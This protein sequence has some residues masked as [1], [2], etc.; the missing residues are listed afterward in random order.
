MKESIDMAERRNKAAEKWLEGTS[1]CATLW[2]VEKQ[3]SNS[4]TFSCFAGDTCRCM[5]FHEIR[6]K[7]DVLIESELSS[8]MLL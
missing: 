2:F 5:G 1:W 4:Y 3:S 6:R 7:L 8:N